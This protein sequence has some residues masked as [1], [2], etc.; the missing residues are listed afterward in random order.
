MKSK[1][2]FPFLIISWAEGILALFSL[3][4]M[5]FTPGRGG[6][7]DYGTLKWLLAGATVLVLVASAISIIGLFLRPAWRA[8]L[9][10]LLEERLLAGGKR[11]FFI[12][13][14]LILLAIFLLECFFLTY[15]AFPE[16]MRP[17]FLWACLSSACS[18][19]SVFRLAYSGE[20]RQHHPS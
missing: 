2:I 18:S 20:Y 19:G 7:V 6:T 9:S 13:P 11:L 10:T 1:T 8:R 16:P 17:F 5:T 14:A 4:G 3:L 15:L 12:Q